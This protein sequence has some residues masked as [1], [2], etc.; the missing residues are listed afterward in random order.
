[1]LPYTESSVYIRTRVPIWC[2][3]V[4]RILRT[5]DAGVH[6]DVLSLLKTSVPFN[7]ILF[8]NNRIMMLCTCHSSSSGVYDRLQ[9]EM[10][11][12]RTITIIRASPI[13]LVV[14]YP[15]LLHM[16]IQKCTSESLRGQHPSVCSSIE[17]DNQD[18]II[19]SKK[20]MMLGWNGS[21]LEPNMWSWWCTPLKISTMF[22]LLWSP[23]ITRKVHFFCFI[24]I[25]NIAPTKVSINN[26]KDALFCFILQ[27]LL[28]CQSTLASLDHL[29]STSVM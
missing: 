29:S 5:G 7:T 6:A 10:A 24:S 14:V 23:S 16:R 28:R 26:K 20:S 8:E 15:F 13:W 22:G 9:L 4:G 17:G 21:E 25:N 11:L 19:I 2:L 27:F 1:M 12:G 18:V 3:S